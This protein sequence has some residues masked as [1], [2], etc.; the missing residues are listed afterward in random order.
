VRMPALGGL[1]DPSKRAAEHSAA[2]GVGGH[3]SS[4]PL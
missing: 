2:A 1:A 3:R 4:S